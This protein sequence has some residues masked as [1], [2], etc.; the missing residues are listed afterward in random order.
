MQLSLFLTFRMNEKDLQMTSIAIFMLA[1]LKTKA[2][3][4]LFYADFLAIE[5][6]VCLLSPV[7]QFQIKDSRFKSNISEEKGI[8][9]PVTPSGISTCTQ[10]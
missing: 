6:L 10:Y 9:L 1:A 7:F 3:Y 4:C 2:T 8:F 5:A